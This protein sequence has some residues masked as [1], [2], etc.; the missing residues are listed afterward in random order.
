M[1]KKIAKNFL[2]LLD[3]V[4][5]DNLQYCNGDILS[6]IVGLFKIAEK[7]NIDMDM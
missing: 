2:E 5:M 1:E 6:C 7:R 4:D 3:F